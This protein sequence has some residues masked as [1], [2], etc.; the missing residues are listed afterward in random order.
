MSGANL[1]D[2]P[3]ELTAHLG[4][5]SAKSVMRVREREAPMALRELDYAEAGF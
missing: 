3:L 5:I 4:R 1:V 2:D